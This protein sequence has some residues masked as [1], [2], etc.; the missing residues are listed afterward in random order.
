LARAV[1]QLKKIVKIKRAYEL[2]RGSFNAAFRSIISR[3]ESEAFSIISI[4]R[5]FSDGKAILE[6]L[7]CK[8]P[9]SDECRIRVGIVGEIYVVMEDSINMNIAE[10]LNNLGCEVVRSM[11]ISD[12]I[13]HNLCPK[14]FADRSGQKLIDNNRPYVEIPVG[15][16]YGCSN[17]CEVTEIAADDRIVARWGDRCGKWTNSIQGSGYQSVN[18]TFSGISV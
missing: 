14:I 3:F 6:S 4:R 7:P 16:H 2:N 9:I 12:W 1:D 10:I 8:N 15:G 13:D 17:R 18:R 11:C 5:L